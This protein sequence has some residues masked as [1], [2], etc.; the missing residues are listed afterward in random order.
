MANSKMA[1]ASLA[2]H[3][4]PFTCLG[5]SQPS[6]LAP[7]PPDLVRW[8]KREGGFV[9]HAVKLSQETPFGVGLISAEHIPQGT[10]LIALPPHVP[11]R[12]ESDDSSSSSSSLLATL[13]RRVP[14]KCLWLLISVPS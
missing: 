12:F 9:H 8:I 1:M 3:I 13:A 11:L 6:R 2:A 7:H 4:R 10:D 5:A 14:G